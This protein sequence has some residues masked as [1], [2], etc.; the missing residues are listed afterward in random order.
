MSV[1]AGSQGQCGCTFLIPF[2]GQT[3]HLETPLAPGH[4]H[5]SCLQRGRGVPGLGDGAQLP[6]AGILRHW[7]RS[8]QGSALLNDLLKQLTQWFSQDSDPCT[9]LVLLCCVSARVPH[10][11]ALLMPAASGIPLSPIFAHSRP[12]LQSRAYLKQGWCFPR[13]LGAARCQLSC[14][15]G[16][17]GSQHSSHSPSHL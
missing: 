2:P 10:Q 5:R 4:G 13:A 14:E 12:F 9:T 17:M 7:C 6:R 11:G 8:R 3:P 1:H 16:R 15:F